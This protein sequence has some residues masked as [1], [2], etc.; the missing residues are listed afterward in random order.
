V[1]NQPLFAGKDAST[2]TVDGIHPTTAAA[3]AIAKQVWDRMQ[4][5]CV[6]Q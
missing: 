6:A 4:K 3:D 2:Y 5:D 1:D